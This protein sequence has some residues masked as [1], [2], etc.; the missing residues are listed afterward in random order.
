MKINN[1]FITSGYVSPEY[2]CDRESE[3]KQIIEAISSN[4]NL[5]LMSLRRMGKTA[6]LRHVENSLSGRKYELLYIDLLPTQSSSEFLKL[7]GNSVISAR[8]KERSFVD[9]I[10][11][12]L[13]GLR[14]VISF[15]SLTGQPSVSFSVTNPVET[16]NGIKQLIEVI[17]QLKKRVIIVLDEFQ[18]INAYPE[19]N[20]EALLRS[21]VQQY[22]TISFIFSGSNKHMLEAMFTS[23]SRPFFGS[24][25][26][27]NL[28]PITRENYNSFIIDKFRS[29]GK[30]IE[31]PE[32]NSILD[33]CRLHTFYVQYF[34]NRLFSS[35]NDKVSP[36]MIERIKNEILDSFT[37]SFVTFRNL[38]TK[39]QF[40]LLKAIA[41]ETRVSR[42]LA[43]DFLEKYNFK[44]ASTIKT[45]L[46]ALAD[47]EMIVY[48]DNAWLVYDVFLMRWLEK[49]YH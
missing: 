49:N 9:K 1:P 21:I 2:F 3:K 26:I 37:P 32:V 18:Q 47:K 43:G 4:R 17:A 12:S 28:Y 10:I 16:G 29:N 30:Q 34:C 20:L 33:W 46:D 7:L 14:P 8:N 6:L 13:G 15:D 40:D 23:T 19:K 41:V 39:T 11:K 27:M 25:D 44:A 5:T 24:V 35:A 22:P 48:E 45:S 38:L 31:E 42:P 36:G